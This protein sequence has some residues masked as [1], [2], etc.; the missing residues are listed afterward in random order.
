MAILLS[1]IIF[2]GTGFFLLK[3]CHCRKKDH[4]KGSLLSFFQNKISLNRYNYPAL[5]QIIIL[6]WLRKLKSTQEVQ[7]VIFIKQADVIEKYR[8]ALGHMVQATQTSSKLGLK[9]KNNSEIMTLGLT[10]LC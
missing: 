7:E 9:I 8:Q 1:L 3:F 6:L 5:L 10:L 2:Q 4:I